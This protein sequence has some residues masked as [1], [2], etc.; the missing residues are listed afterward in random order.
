MQ[1]GYS[2]R[3]FI[4]NGSGFTC[5]EKVGLAVGEIT[6]DHLQVERLFTVSIIQPV[7]IMKHDA[8]RPRRQSD[9]CCIWGMP[10][11]SCRRNVNASILFVNR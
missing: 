3:D 1:S 6:E 9:R 7:K 2:G 5:E 8:K 11:S 10:C 4:S